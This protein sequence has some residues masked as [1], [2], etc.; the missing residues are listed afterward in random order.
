MKMKFD[1]LRRDA[2]VYAK[3]NFLD[4][5][6]LLGLI[7]RGPSRVWDEIVSKHRKKTWKEPWKKPSL[8]HSTTFGKHEGKKRTTN[9]EKKKKEF[10]WIF[11]F[12]HSILTFSF[13]LFIFSPPVIHLH[14]NPHG[15]FGTANGHLTIV[16][17]LLLVM[18]RTS[19]LSELFH[20]LPLL[21]PSHQEVFLRLV[22]EEKRKHLQ[23]KRKSRK[24]FLQCSFL[25]N[26]FHFHRHLPFSLLLLLL[27]ILPPPP[28]RKE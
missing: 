24:M 18:R 2:K 15:D 1:E 20:L 4:E 22:A 19:L 16:Q 10:V 12:P 28:K 25:T 6:L 8:R 5:G 17:L 21:L 13:F 11:I 9:S 3:W 7:E 23:G 27:S 14:S 26:H